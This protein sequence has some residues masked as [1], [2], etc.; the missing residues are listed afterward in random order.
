[1]FKVRNFERKVLA[2]CV[3]VSGKSPE[4]PPA[5]D[6]LKSHPGQC[7][8]KDGPAKARKE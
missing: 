8:K 7:S 2:V 5:L 4:A 3:N 1:V 6:E